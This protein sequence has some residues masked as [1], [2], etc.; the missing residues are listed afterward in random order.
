VRGIPTEVPLGK[1]EGVKPG[2]VANLDNI[3]L[4]PVELLIAP[5]GSVSPARWNEFCFAAHEMMGC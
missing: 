1:A 3:Q 4:L 5:A 2:S